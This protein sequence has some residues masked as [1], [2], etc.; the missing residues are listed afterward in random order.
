MEQLYHAVYFDQLNDISKNGLGLKLGDT[1]IAPIKLEMY[2]HF[3]EMKQ[4]ALNYNS[5][6]ESL[7]E[8]VVLCVQISSIEEKYLEPI[9]AKCGSVT[10]YYYGDIIDS[11]DI[12]M[13]WA[14]MTFPLNDFTYLYSQI[15]NAGFA[16]SESESLIKCV[17]WFS[18][19]PEKRKAIFSIIGSWV[20]TYISELAVLTGY[21]EDQLNCLWLHKE[22]TK[23]SFYTYKNSYEKGMIIGLFEAGHSIEEIKE[24]MN[25]LEDDVERVLQEND[26]YAI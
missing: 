9:T 10:G 23:E 14:D 15:Q 7:T 5:W 21:S 13:V 12:S 19:V 26:L 18:M 22:K 17:Q 20:A 24:K 2:P 6:K 1:D 11:K 8:F 4:I 3:A 16:A 25:W